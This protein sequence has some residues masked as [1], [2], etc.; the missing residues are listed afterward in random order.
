MARREER[1]RVDA[2][3]SE[4]ASRWGQEN[5]NR[6]RKLIY[7]YLDQ[8]ENI[9]GLVG[10]TW[11]PASAF[12]EGAGLIMRQQR[13][14]GAVVVTDIGIYFVAH[15][16]FNK[17]VTQMSLP[18]ITA[19]EHAS[20]VVTVAGAGIHNWAG[21][22]QGG[23]F[24]IRDVHGY[25][26]ARFAELVQQVQAAP[27]SPEARPQAAPPSS[28]APSAVQDPAV[29]KSQRIDAQWQDRSLMPSRKQGF[30]GLLSSFFGDNRKSYDSEREKLHE[31]L[32]DDESI[33]YWMGG[34]WG[35]P[36]DFPQFDVS[37]LMGR[38][39]AR[40]REGH[41]GIAVAT[42][43]R[44]LLLRSGV[45]GTREIELPYDRIDDVEYND[46]MISSGVEFRGNSIEP[47]DFYF[48]HQ[49]KPRVKGQ[50]RRFADHV[51][52]HLVTPPAADAD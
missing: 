2:Q 24:Q 34:R 41:Q 52:Q 16:G 1:N 37:E 4:Q 5:H 3:W 18:S 44:V 33:E 45:L 29:N 23:P 12:A 39:F 31:V 7:D 14:K 40:N 35:S 42:D 49:N 25:Q 47:Y 51:R 28:S 11:G 36:D 8:D 13:L 19:V 26:G 9:M 48:D 17:L 32:E 30:L 43:R 22:Q 38:G 27:P 6:E 20:G 15:K 50:A 46:G 10:C 21:Q